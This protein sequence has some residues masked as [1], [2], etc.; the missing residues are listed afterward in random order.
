MNLKTFLLCV[1]ACTIPAYA[2]EEKIKKTS[3]TDELLF[4]LISKKIAQS[5]CLKRLCTTKDESDPILTEYLYVGEL[6]DACSPEMNKGNDEYRQI[7]AH[8]KF[9]DAT[10]VELI[11]AGESIPLGIKEKFQNTSWFDLQNWLSNIT[12]INL[13][14]DFFKCTLFSSKKKDLKP[15]LMCEGKAISKHIF[16]E[17][18]K[19]HAD[20]ST[21]A[22]VSKN[23]NH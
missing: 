6:T 7:V 1:L 23:M 15:L 13:E 17:A 3:A 18:I 21:L 8:S 2:A 19:K 16:L 5:R 11:V 14:T 20:P 9:S 22:M 10:Q 4:D 12:L